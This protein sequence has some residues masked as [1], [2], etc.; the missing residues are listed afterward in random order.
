LKELVEALQKELLN[1]EAYINGQKQGV[2]WELESVLRD[3]SRLQ[4]QQLNLQ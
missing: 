4:V 3:R 2:E 1:K